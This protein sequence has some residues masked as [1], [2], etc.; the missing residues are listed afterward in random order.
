MLWILTISACSRDRMFVEKFGAGQP[1]MP[2]LWFLG[3]LFG[4]D[5]ETMAPNCQGGGAIQEGLEDVLLGDHM[6]FL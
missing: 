1:G 5:R 6:R 3:S 2:D 4:C